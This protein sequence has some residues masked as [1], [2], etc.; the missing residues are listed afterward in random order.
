MAPLGFHDGVFAGCRVLIDRVDAI[1]ADTGVWIV[2]AFEPV[3]LHIRVS[4]LLAIGT[5]LVIGPL[6]VALVL[7]VPD[8]VLVISGM[9]VCSRITG[10]MWLLAGAR[11]VCGARV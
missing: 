9:V 1:L 7:V 6:R 8:T 2:D 10:V 3:R 5:L 11:V 4:G